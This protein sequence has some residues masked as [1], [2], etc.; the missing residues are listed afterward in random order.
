MPRRKI[1]I[2]LIGNRRARAV[3]Y[4]KRK[5]GLMKKARELATLC[6]IPVAV[7][8]AGPDDGAPAEGY[9]ALAL[10]KK[11]GHTHRAYLREQLGK[12]KAKLAKLR[13]DGPDE[14]APPDAALKGMALD[15]LHRLLE[16][17]DVTLR[18]MAERRKALG[19]LADDDGDVDGGWPHAAVPLGPNGVPY[20][21]ANFVGL[22]G[23]QQQVHAPAGNGVQLRQ[24]TWNPYQPYDAG[25]P[26][27]GYNVQYMGG[28]GVNMNGYPLQMPS[29]GNINNHGRQFAWGAFQPRNAF[30]QSSYDHLQYPDSNDVSG[31][32]Q[33]QA[34][35]NGGWHNPYTWGNGEP[36]NA[37]V[38]AGYSYVD[39]RGDNSM[40]TPVQFLTVDSDESFIYVGGGGGGYGTQCSVGEVLHCSDASQNSSSL[41][42]L[43]YLSD[44]ADGLDFGSGD[45]PL[46]L[47][48]WED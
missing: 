24:F 44:L 8:C 31:N 12:L 18:A 14:L 35:V 43:H 5:E 22:H 26:Q 40:D 2:S 37:I 45:E 3:T 25:V 10:E 21:G 39:T 4:A 34:P 16:S 13:Q 15:E 47:D 29:N 20:T 9:C 48:L 7:V 6:D 42:Q 27:A 23:Y 11:A 46:V 30:V 17:I 1:A 19:L 28:H 33:M 38:P 41:E 36:C 32:R